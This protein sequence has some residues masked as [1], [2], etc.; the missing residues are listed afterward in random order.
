M[1]CTRPIACKSY[2]NTVDTTRVYICRLVWTEW[3]CWWSTHRWEWVNSWTR[4]PSRP[5]DWP[6]FMPSVHE[7]WPAMT[8]LATAACP[9][10]SE[11]CC[12]AL[13]THNRTPQ[14]YLVFR[15][16]NST[17]HSE[18]YLLGEPGLPFSN[19]DQPFLLLSWSKMQPVPSRLQPEPWPNSWNQH[20]QDRDQTGLLGLPANNNV[21]HH[22]RPGFSEA[23]V[24]YSF[25]QLPSWTSQVTCDH[26][27]KL[28]LRSTPNFSDQD[29]PQG[30]TVLLGLQASHNTQTSPG[31]TWWWNN[32]D[33]R[34]VTIRG[35][36]YNFRPFHFQVTI[37][38]KFFSH[39]YL[40]HQAV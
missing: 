4:W 23:W 1:N 2:G 25:P 13:Q 37:F 31:M 19:L 12:T 34:H 17:P 21:P 7:A 5:A 3:R 15:Q 40:C 30:Q 35:H 38:G 9:A 24:H 33:I 16:V 14:T 18:R 29:W 27:S 10:L 6:S 8:T 39:V 20:H 22:R 32:L 28:R 26:P 11:F 36:G